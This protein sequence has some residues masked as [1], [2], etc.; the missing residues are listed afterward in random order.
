MAAENVD[1]VGVGGGDD[2]VGAVHPRLPQDALGGAVALEAHDVKLVRK[3][4]EHIVLGVDDGDA[5]PFLRQVLGQS[6]AHLACPCHDDIQSN[7]SPL[8]ALAWEYL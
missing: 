1:L 8:T 6:G 3:A 7:T 4:A 2:D 5:V